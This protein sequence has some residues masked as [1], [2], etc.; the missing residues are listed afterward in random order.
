MEKRKVYMDYAATTPM[1]K[2]V[3][4]A[5]MPYYTELFGN[6]SSIHCFGREVKSAL[7]TAREEVAKLINANTSEIYF[8]AGGTEADNWAI[9]GYAFANKE[10]GNHI[11]TT[12][13]EHH[14]VLHTCEYLE[15]YHGFEVTYLDVD[16]DGIVDLKQLRES[17]K[18]TTIL[19]SVMFANNEI[20]TIQPIKE[21]AQIAKEKGIAF[22]TDAVQAVGNVKV[23]VK[24]LDIDLMAMS[25]HKIYGPKGVGALYVKKGIKLHPLVHGGAQEKKRRAGTENIA[26]IVGFG[27]AAQIARINLDNHIEKLTSLREKL[28]NGVLD[29]IPYTRLNGHRTN[30]LPGNANF[31]FEFIEGEALLL[32][33]DMLGIAG[34]S[35]SACTSGSLDPSHV[36]MAIG[37]SHEIAHGSLRL[38]L[39]DMNTE[40]DVDYVLDNLPKIVE[41][42]RMM[43]PLYEKVTKGGN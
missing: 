5:M 22:H 25:S 13:I 7:E 8:T 34:S 12:K 17:I 20:G 29:K 36:L 24:E 39:G 28:I 40:E 42:L 1:K 4:D 18:D 16:K 21:I 10:R 9:K 2:E 32:S 37:L 26:G 27:K 3:L 23:D 15:K 33:L 11:I 38:S 35:G 41:R 30:R 6:A 31:S 43:S 14:A 19:I